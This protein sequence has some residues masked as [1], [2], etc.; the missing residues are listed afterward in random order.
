M[1]HITTQRAAAPRGYRIRLHD[2]PLKRFDFPAAVAKVLGLSDMAE[3][4][5]G[6]T[7]EAGA[8]LGDTVAHRTFYA[9]FEDL[10]D[11]YQDFVVARIFPLFQ[12]SICVQRTPTFRIAYPGGVAVRE[13]HV[14]ADYNHQHGTVNFWLPVTRAFDT[15]TMWMESAP[16]RGDYQPANLRPGQVLEFDATLLRHGNRPNTTESTRVSFDFRVIPL[17]DYRPRGLRSVSAGVPIR[18]GAYYSLLMADGTFV[19]GRESREVE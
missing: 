7:P 9:G 4:D 16:G 10:R 1:V 12:Q 19:D 11:L 15:N 6:F 5:R 13:F 2:Y 3:V 14:D 17:K 8:D 18:L